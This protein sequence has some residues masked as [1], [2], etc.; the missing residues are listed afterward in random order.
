MDIEGFSKPPQFTENDKDDEELN[1][2]VEVKSQSEVDLETEAQLEALE[3]QEV[4]DDPVRLYLHEIGKVHLLTGDDE[5][6]LA[7]KIEEG[8]RIADI[9]FFILFKLYFVTSVQ[10]IIPRYP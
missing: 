6:Y 7:R 3:D 1:N 8:K 2:E 10:L 9:Y 4:G 5:K